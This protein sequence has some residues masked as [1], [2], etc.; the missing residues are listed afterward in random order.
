MISGGAN[1]MNKHGGHQIKCMQW[2]CGLAMCVRNV[3]HD[4]KKQ[5]SSSKSFQIP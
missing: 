3:P 5:I 2:V 1:R 4:W